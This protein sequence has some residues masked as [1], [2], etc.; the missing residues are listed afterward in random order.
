MG[1]KAKPIVPLGG[2]I[3]GEG[4]LKQWEP[5]VH[6]MIRQFN[7]F[8]VDYEDAQQDLR[9]IILKS[10]QAFKP[11]VGVTFHTFLHG[12]MENCLGQC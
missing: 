6:K 5:K 7:L 3:D 9:E 2:G 4:L 1:R 8:G 10:A 11:E 12:N